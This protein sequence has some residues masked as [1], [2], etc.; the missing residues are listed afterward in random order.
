MIALHKLN[1]DTFYLNC[2]LIERIETNPDTV[3]TLID[4]KTIR[5]VERAEEIVELIK[6]YR[7]EISR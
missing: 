5:V 6:K 7:K 1:D 3:I 4:G 2:D